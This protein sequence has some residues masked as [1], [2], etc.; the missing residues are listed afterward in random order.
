MKAISSVSLPRQLLLLTMAG[1]LVLAASGEAAAQV[2]AAVDAPRVEAGREA[3]RDATSGGADAAEADAAETDAEENTSVESDA[4][5][6][7]AGRTTDAGTARDGATASGDGGAPTGD[8]GATGDAR[9]AT[10]GG[11][12]P[13]STALMVPPSPPN[14]PTLKGPDRDPALEG[15]NPPNEP[16]KQP[17]GCSYGAGGAGVGSLLVVGSLIAGLLRRRRRS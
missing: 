15:T 11:A 17:G 14:R 16:H 10:D 13:P 3:G 1:G 5:Q 12:A 4:A 9:P 6:A 7:E 2:D 8:G